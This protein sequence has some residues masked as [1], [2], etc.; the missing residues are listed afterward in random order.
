[1]TRISRHASKYMHGLYKT[2]VDDDGSDDGN[3]VRSIEPSVG[4]VDGQE[5]L[6]FDISQIG[7]EQVTQDG[8]VWDVTKALA[9]SHALGANQLVIRIYRRD[10]RMRPY[11]EVVRKS[12]PFLLVFSKA[13]NTLDQERVRRGVEG[14]RR[15]R[16]EAGYYTYSSTGEYESPDEKEKHEKEVYRKKGLNIFSPYSKGIKLR[17][18]RRKPKENDVWHGFG[19]NK[20]E[21]T[22]EETKV[23]TESSNDVRV[24]L[25]DG[26]E[27][28]KGICKKHKYVVNFADMGWGEWVDTPSTFEAGYCAGICP[29]PLPEVIVTIFDFSLSNEVISLLN[30]F[31]LL[32]TFIQET[33][34]SNHAILQSLLQSDNMPPVCC[35]PDQMESLTI[36][37]K[38]QHGRLTIRNFPRMIVKSCACL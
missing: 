36:L 31:L 28:K 35:A 34:P 13:N 3:V 27:R 16:R 5:V 24:V 26:E 23:V 37:Y 15:K 18:N 2:F 1:M 17:A 7:E 4:K 21:S 32:T 29:N 10:V 19:D 38:D 9:E 14:T 20:E 30:Y 12:S 33:H 8:A 25:L 11:S 22:D 6:I